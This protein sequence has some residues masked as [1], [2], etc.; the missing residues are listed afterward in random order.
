MNEY[1]GMLAPPGEFG[2]K[3]MKL[4]AGM[5]IEFGKT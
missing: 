2:M 5:P 3:M 4:E 1:V